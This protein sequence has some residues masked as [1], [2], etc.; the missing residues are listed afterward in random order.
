MS[1]PPLVEALLA[2]EATYNKLLELVKT[3]VPGTDFDKMNS[4]RQVI[5]AELRDTLAHYVPHKPCPVLRLVSNDGH[6]GGSIGN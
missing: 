3:E 2:I 4:T 5:V 1:L 6:S